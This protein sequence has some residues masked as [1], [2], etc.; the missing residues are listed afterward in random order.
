MDDDEMV[1]ASQR[2]FHDPHKVPTVFTNQVGVSGFLNGVVNVTLLTADFVVMKDNSVRTES[3]I[4]S[5]LRMDLICA[6][7]LRDHLDK[8]INEQAHVREA[9]HA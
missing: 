1:R 5:N 6:T 9:G 2:A 3:V 4:A 7:Q 8:I